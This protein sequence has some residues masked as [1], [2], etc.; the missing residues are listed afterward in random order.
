M[1]IAGWTTSGDRYLRDGIPCGNHLSSQI[2]ACVPHRDLGGVDIPF[3]APGVERQLILVQY[4]FRAEAEKT[5][6]STSA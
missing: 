1:P 4:A 5:R 6:L 3:H 2:T